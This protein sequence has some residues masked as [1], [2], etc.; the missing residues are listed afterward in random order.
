[1]A[2]STRLVILIKN[3]FTLWGRKRF[4]LPCAT[5]S[6]SLYVYFNGITL[7]EKFRCNSFIW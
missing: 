3:V 5:I 6:M 7:F 2:R 1:M 4:F